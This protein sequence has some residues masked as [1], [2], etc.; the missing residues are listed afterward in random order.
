MIL[1][2]LALY[3]REQ[4]AA[5]LVRKGCTGTVFENFEV[6]APAASIMSVPGKLVRSY[7]GRAIEV[8]STTANDAGFIDETANF[9]A[10]MSNEILQGSVAKTVKAGSEVSEVRDSAHPEYISQLFTGYLR[11]MGKEVEPR[12][13]VKRVADEVLWDKTLKP[14][15]RS[16]IWLI[17]R[18]ALQTSLAGVEHYKNFLVYFQ[19]R[20]LDDCRKDSSF[21]SDLLFAM[22]AK[23]ARR[24]LKIQDS[25]PQFVV[26]A[27][28]DAADQ[29]EGVLQDR[30]TQVQSAVPPL[31]PLD[32]DSSRDTVQSLPN[33]RGYLNKVL[34]GRSSRNAPPL[35]V[36]SHRPRL[37]DVVNFAAFNN[38]ALST[39]YSADGHIAL[40]DFESAVYNQLSDWTTN[41]I[42]SE[43]SCA[44]ISSC[45]DQYT[46][47]ATACYAHDV[48]DRSIMILTVLE[49][50]VSLDRL[51]TTQQP[52]LRDYSPEIPDNLVESL[53]LRT[54][55]HIKQA[56]R[57]QSYLRGRHANANTGSVFTDEASNSSLSVRYFR[58]TPSLQN[59]KRTI[60]QH[61]QREKEQKIQELARKHQER[62][63]LLQSANSRSC[64]QWTNWNGYTRHDRYCVKCRIQREAGNIRIDIH[65]WPLPSTQ[66]DA[67]AAV[68]ELECPDAIN[69][70]RSVT[71]KIMCDL[72]G[73]SRSARTEP[74]C[75]LGSY[76]AL[77]SWTSRIR[78][79]SHRIT[80]ASSTKSFLH[81]HYSSTLVP[82]TA[83]A[84]CV[85]NG[86]TFQLFDTDKQTWAAGPFNGTSFAKYSTFSLPTESSY[87]HLGYALDGTTHS[88]NKVIA[89]QSDCPKDLSLHEHYAFG[90]LRSGP[91]LQWM[92]MVRGLE[93]N[94]LTSS[95]EEVD[96]LH[97][98][99]AWQIGPLS[100]NE[101]RDWHLDLSD[102]QY[103]RLLVAQA[104]RV[105][106]RIKGN[107]LEATSV[108]TISMFFHSIYT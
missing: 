91:L 54:S 49:L 21:S 30:W 39:A 48:A 97:T 24:L 79:S 98:Q 56:M 45:L 2:V 78:S 95:R 37:V 61:A 68:F 69:I 86:L 75:T 4:N 19:A 23:M 60:E 25:V 66:L 102:G 26:D 40:F 42:H 13:V 43:S 96:L 72:G 105:L 58:Q 84:V 100:Q 11:G 94:I 92:N 17:I 55:H 85:N 53:L 80:I 62:D 8:P 3:I 87:Q 12:R 51:A 107:W 52:L 82:T 27:A 104:L 7:P 29:T 63:S 22:R 83:A 89:D 31:S 50:W 76:S 10:R 108:R 20:L 47:A 81:S 28:K 64:D 5:V 59:L 93:E 74:H 44:V 1:D 35:F 38:G 6:Q 18:V 88:S 9:L 99:A 71:Y 77:S 103:G 41:N 16:P 36:P 73:S 57:V 90:T 65:E 46:S 33:S 32:L 101:D 106:N 34:Q 67:E 70:W 14:W 15:R